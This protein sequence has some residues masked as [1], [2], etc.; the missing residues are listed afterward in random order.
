MA[1]KFDR[2]NRKELKERG[3]FPIPIGRKKAQEAQ[4]PGSI[5]LVCSDDAQQFLARNAR[6]E[7]RRSEQRRP[8]PQYI[9]RPFELSR[10]AAAPDSSTS[11][12][13]KFGIHLFC[14]FSHDPCYDPVTT[15][16]NLA[17]FRPD[18]SD[19]PLASFWL[20]GLNFKLPPPPQMTD[21]SIS[22]VDFHENDAAGAVSASYNKR[23]HAW[24]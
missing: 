17:P 15:A 7:E 23:V 19:R 22:V 13:V 16:L 9:D 14:H 12:I 8:L 21:G 24:R 18:P 6:D 4:N 3:V 2:F 5:R 20:I 11:R 10:S 1:E